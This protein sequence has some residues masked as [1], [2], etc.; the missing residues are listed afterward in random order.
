MDAATRFQRH[1]ELWKAGNNRSQR[2]AVGALIFASA[3]FFNVIEPYSN[4]AKGRADLAG[5]ETK[6]RQA[7]V[8][9]ARMSVFADR[10]GG[11]SQAVERADWRQYKEALVQ[12][13]RSGQV[14]APQGEADGTV[15]QIAT[16]V[17]GEVLTAL[18]D[19]VAQSGVDGNLAEFP[20]RMEADIDAWERENIGQRWFETLNTKERTV[21]E[22][23]ATLETIQTDA[24]QVLLGLQNAVDARRTQSKQAQAKLA[25]DIEAKRSEIQ[26]ALNE[27]IPA[28]AKGLISVERM[29]PI[30]P[31]ILVGIAIYL[32]GSALVAARHYHGMASAVGWSQPERSDPLMSS[33]WT[34]T[35]RGATGTAISLLSYVGVLGTLGHFVNRSIKL[36]GAG[37]PVGWLLEL[38]LFLSLLTVI[39][40]PFRERLGRVGL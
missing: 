1:A 25:A 40:T 32:V 29:V 35:W 12:R 4:T 23:G 34:L 6:Q 2:T 18:K 16:H 37:Q 28:W 20:K 15:R 19:A 14:T 13:F 21:G 3:I 33:V 39:A 24:K 17:R 7:E 31:W 8:E 38:V 5:F 36:A 10:L 9:F 27:P 22:L 30:C 26:E 11:I